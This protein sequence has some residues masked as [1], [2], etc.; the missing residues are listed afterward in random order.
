MLML[1]V[2]GECK[3]ADDC[4]CYEM[5]SDDEAENFFRNGAKFIHDCMI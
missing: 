2:D 3:K 4:S 1:L 5:L